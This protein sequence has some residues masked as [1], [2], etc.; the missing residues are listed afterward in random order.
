MAETSITRDEGIA[1]LEEEISEAYEGDETYELAYILKRLIAEDGITPQGAAQQIDSYYEDDLLPSQ[2][3]LQKEKA[4]G[5]INLLGALDDLICGLGSVLHYND[6]RQDALIQLILELRKLP[7]RQVVIGDNECT[8][9]KDNPIFVRQVYENW[10]GYQVYDSLPGTPLE[11]QESC[12]KYVNWSSFIAR[13]T[14]AGFLADK[15]GYEYKY[16]TVDISSGLEEE[17]PQGKI[18]NARILA[19]ANYILLAGSGIRNYCHSYS[20]D[21]DRRRRAWEMWNVWKE[22]F[23]AI[24]NGQDEDPDIK[25]A[26]EKA[27]AVMVELDA[28][29]HDAPENPP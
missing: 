20:S 12:D 26:A 16:S 14:S 15:E 24:A 8:D 25:N 23:E 11:V 29:G 3:I 22:K 13:C 6:V 9:Y 1:Y 7:P 27:H 17:I 4:K 28:S 5:M 21:S 10:N 18:R 19:A 2:P